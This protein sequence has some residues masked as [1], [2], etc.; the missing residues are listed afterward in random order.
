MKVRFRQVTVKVYRKTP[1]YPF[2]RIAYRADGKR[3]VRN[4]KRL[5]QAK[6]E[7]E[8]KARELAHGNEAG[9]ALSEADAHAYKFALRKL[10]ELRTGLIV[11]E[12]NAASPDL[13]LSLEDAIAEYVEAKRL[14]GPTRLA[15]VVKIYLSTVARV[16]R[17]NLKTAADEFPAERDTRT[18]A[19]DGKRAA[20][21]SAWRISRSICC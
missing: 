11:F 12:S 15:E 14:L 7:A 17:V 13:P 21:S 8:K 18:T 3:V 4:L 19:E 2:Y 20:L 1:R 5:N 9:A 10:V 16:R 6:Q